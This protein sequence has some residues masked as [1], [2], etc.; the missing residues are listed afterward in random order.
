METMARKHPKGEL[1]GVP[2]RQRED[3]SAGVVRKSLVSS[4]QQLRTVVSNTQLPT[5]QPQQQPS[6]TSGPVPA[7]T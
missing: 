5:T 1:K 6:T 3:P 7:T 2:Q 4:I